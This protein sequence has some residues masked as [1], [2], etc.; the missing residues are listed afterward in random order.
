MIRLSTTRLA[1][2]LTLGNILGEGDELGLLD[3]EPLKAKAVPVDLAGGQ[4]A[5]I[6]A[7]YK[8]YGRL[9][10][11]NSTALLEEKILARR[12]RSIRGNMDQCAHLQGKRP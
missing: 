3:V 11:E 12:L 4:F 8:R 7:F 9:P 10:E 6:V 5:E 1:N 2:K